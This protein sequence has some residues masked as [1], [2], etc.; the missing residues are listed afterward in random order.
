MS[1][2][3]W[4]QPKIQAMTTNSKSCTINLESFAA[5][6]SLVP[7][8]SAIFDRLLLSAKLSAEERIRDSR[9]YTIGLSRTRTSTLS[10]Q[11]WLSI[12]KVVTYYEDQCQKTR[13]LQVPCTSARLSTLDHFAAMRDWLPHTLL[14]F[15]RRRWLTLSW[16]RSVT[17]FSSTAHIRDFWVLQKW[18]VLSFVILGA[19]RC[20]RKSP[21]TSGIPLLVLYTLG[22]ILEQPNHWWHFRTGVINHIDIND[23]CNKCRLRQARF[24]KSQVMYKLYMWT[25]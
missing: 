22:S 5:S 1:T 15:V 12:Y 21:C 14:A 6:Q 19:W 25:C 4:S 24:S 9:K 7:R 16:V 13:D 3:Q 2:E 23:G 11:N 18:H 10:Q 8:S 17:L 20:L